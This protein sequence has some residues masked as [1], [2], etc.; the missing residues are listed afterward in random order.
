MKISKKLTGILVCATLLVPVGHSHAS[1]KQEVNSDIH[2]KAQPQQSSLAVIQSL[3]Y[4]YGA[5]TF[6]YNVYINGGQYYYNPKDITI[7]PSRSVKN[8]SIALIKS[9]G[10][11]KK[12]ELRVVLRW[13]SCSSK[14]LKKWRW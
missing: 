3:T 11:S 4:R 1:E 13:N 6:G 8:M 2:I 7:N 5:T 14:Q 9:D 10:T 12:N